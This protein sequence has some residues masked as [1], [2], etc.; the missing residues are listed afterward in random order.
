M[1]GNRSETVMLFTAAADAPVGGRLVDV[2]GRT[3][4]PKQPIEGHLR[5]RSSL[6]RGQ[7]QV[8]MWS[9]FAD[10]MPLAVTEESPFT[11]DLV[12]PKVPLVRSGAID[13]KVIAKRKEGFTGPIAVKM[14]YNPPGVGSPTSVTIPEGQSEALLPLTATAAA[15]LQTWRIIVLGE[16]TIAEGQV[17]ASTGFVNLEVAEPYLAFTFQA[18]TVEQGQ[19][20]ELIVKME[21]RK[22]F[23][24]PAHVEL[25]GLPN[26]ATAESIDIT[27][28]SSELEFKVKTTPTATAGR[29]KSLLARVVITEKGEPVTHVLGP[30]DLRID[31]PLPPKP[32]AT[33]AAAGAPKPAA[34]AANDK[35]LNR[36]E[37]LR[38]ERE[39][40][41]TESQKK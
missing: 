33:A 10:R 25:V 14:L 23:E 4:D 35:R 22:D 31:T 41:R 16:A 38:K 29:H 20:T 12:E 37:K 27:K 19:E 1:P 8:E 30:G 28:D 24:G 26:G 18:A 2:I 6:A 36:L 40:A 21:K 15:D 7:N 13:L 39:Q 32:N 9:F 3:T 34:T 5:Q 17:L 11:I